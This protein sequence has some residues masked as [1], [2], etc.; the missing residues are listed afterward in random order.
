MSISGHAA[1]SLRSRPLRVSSRRRFLWPAN[2]SV[3]S[4]FPADD[5]T[6]VSPANTD[7]IPRLCMEPV[8]VEAGETSPLDLGRGS[9]SQ[10]GKRVPLV[11]GL[12]SAP[13]LK[14]LGGGRFWLSSE[15]SS[16]SWWPWGRPEA[17][18]GFSSA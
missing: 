17:S 7:D 15:S 9:S 2:G 3:L 12:G 16:A 13:R 14:T 6:P 11:V 5:L 18:R 8:H 1:R 4:A 10:L